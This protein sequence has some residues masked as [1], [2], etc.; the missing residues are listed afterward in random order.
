[1]P[2]T[3]GSDNPMVQH[4]GHRNF[5]KLLRCGVRLFEYPH[6]LLHQKVMT[7]DGV[8]SAVGSSNFDDRVVRDQR[9][10]H[11]RHCSTRRCAQQ[12]D[13]IFE[14]Y[15]PRAREVQAGAWRKRGAVAQAEGQHLLPDQRAALTHRVSGR[16]PSIYSIR[17]P[18][19]WVSLGAKA[20]CAAGR[21][22]V[23]LDGLNGHERHAEPGP[24]PARAAAEASR[25]SEPFTTRRRGGNL[26]LSPAS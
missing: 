21:S 14:K 23:P 26:P 9:R 16:V 25:G 15:V 11:A 7:I 22:P 5:E 6:T 3:S 13:A 17:P 24:R 19:Q 20:P 18:R 8:W 10:D 1:M 2:S 12:L 4:A